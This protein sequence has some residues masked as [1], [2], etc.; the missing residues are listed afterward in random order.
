MV[1]KVYETRILA[2]VQKVW[3]FHS[4]ADALKILTPPG[5]EVTLLSKD[6]AVRDGAIH[7]IQT[8][9]FGLKIV[10]KAK[11]H[12][13]RPP[14]EFT[15]TAIKSPFK[16]W[17]HRHEFIDAEGDTI[18]RDTVTYTPPGGPLRKLVNTMMIEE[19]IDKLFKYRHRVTKEMNE[20]TAAVINPELIGKEGAHYEPFIPGSDEPDPVPGS[21]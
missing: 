6:N 13:V 7:I 9:K 16:S 21:K 14:H 11:I 8:K 18:L 10:W 20:T 4:S 12:G 3:D 2:P 5:Q 1:T 19:E 15:D 17:T